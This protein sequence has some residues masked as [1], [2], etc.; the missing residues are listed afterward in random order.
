MDGIM[1]NPVDTRGLS[2]IILGLIIFT[3]LLSILLKEAD[4]FP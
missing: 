3:L 2:K 4:R 1:P